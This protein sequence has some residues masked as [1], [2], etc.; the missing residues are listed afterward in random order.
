MLKAKRLPESSPT[1]GALVEPGKE[2][3]P[4][5]VSGQ[6]VC[7][8]PEVSSE[9]GRPL[10]TYSRRVQDA[11]SNDGLK[12][13]MDLVQLIVRRDVFIRKKGVIGEVEQPKSSEPD[14]P[15]Q[16]QAGTS[17]GSSEADKTPLK[18][19]K[20]LG[21]GMLPIWLKSE[22]TLDQV[23]AEEH[24]PVEAARRLVGHASYDKTRRTYAE[25]MHGL[26]E[27]PHSAHDCIFETPH[28]QRVVCDFL[29]RSRTPAGCRSVLDKGPEKDSA[30]RTSRKNV[31]YHRATKV[32]RDKSG[33][34]LRYLSSKEDK[35]MN[36]R[37]NPHLQ[38]STGRDVYVSEC[39]RLS[40]LPQFGVEQ[41]LSTNK[42]MGAYKLGPYG[43]LALARALAHNTFIIIVNL[44]DCALGD[45]AAVELCRGLANNPLV[46]ELNLANNGLTVRAGEAL[47]VLLGLGCK[48]KKEH[49]PPIQ[50]LTLDQNKHLHHG[51]KPVLEAVVHNRNLKTLSLNETGM[52]DPVGC[53]LMEVLTEM[54]GRR[55]LTKLTLAWNEMTVAWRGVMLGLAN[56]HT[57]KK[58]DLSNNGLGDTYGTL[59]AQSLASNVSL[60]VLDVCGCRF[61]EATFRALAATFVE[62]NTTL[63]MVVLGV[64]DGSQL[65]K[66]MDCSGSSLRLGLRVEKSGDNAGDELWDVL[67][68]EKHYNMKHPTVMEHTP[69]F[70]EYPCID[71]VTGVSLGITT[72]KRHPYTSGW[73]PVS[74]ATPQGALEVLDPGVQ[75]CED[76]IKEL[77]EALVEEI[78]HSRQPEL[79]C[80]RKSKLE[81]QNRM[82]REALSLTPSRFQEFYDDVIKDASLTSACVSQA[83]ARAKDG[84]GHYEEAAQ[85]YHEA[86][87]IQEDPVMETGFRHALEEINVHRE[88]NT[89]FLRHQILLKIKSVRDTHTPPKPP[90]PRP[91]TP[92]PP[93]PEPAPEPKEEIELLCWEY[94]HCIHSRLQDIMDQHKDPELEKRN[95]REIIREHDTMLHDVYEHYTSQHLSAGI[96]DIPEKINQPDSTGWV[97]ST[98]TSMTTRQRLAC[99]RDQ[100][101]SSHKTILAAEMDRLAILCLWDEREVEEY[102]HSPHINL[103]GLNFYEWVEYICRCSWDMYHKMKHLC[104]RVGFMLKT[105]MVALKDTAMWLKDQ[106]DSFGKKL[107]AKPDGYILL[108]SH[109]SKLL[110]IYKYFNTR[111]KEKDKIAAEEERKAADPFTAPEVKSK[112]HLHRTPK[113]SRGTP[114]TAGLPRTPENQFLAITP[115]TPASTGGDMC[116]S[117]SILTGI[118]KPHRYLEEHDYTMNFND[119]IRMFER[120]ELYDPNLNMKRVQVACD[121]VLMHGELLAQEHPQNVTIEF[122]F[123]QFWEALA[124]CLVATVEK[125][126]VKE[127]GLLVVI[128]DLLI[129]LF[130]PRVARV[131]P[132]R[133]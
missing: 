57:L 133:L 107:W 113:T 127:Q 114:N 1:M 118:G 38:G 115:L 17:K 106:Q 71:A 74:R 59:L 93:M 24:R 116:I 31:L 5:R 105:H 48:D 102:S 62:H 58:L 97:N 123:E 120:L 70:G 78:G 43:G 2:S 90:T 110:R 9:D 14:T 30:E 73:R 64:N 37:A 124:R 54:K 99:N 79:A 7:I 40:I 29:V 103:I 89:P 130:Y 8:K 18:L 129:N 111:E 11:R 60:E 12:S 83:C 63:Q 94:E 69:R 44:R 80:S 61:G 96:D 23:D 56:N 39:A 121:W 65:L 55:Y 49:L 75:I 126:R 10:R 109:R 92:K 6:R 68:D 15:S 53:G 47:G 26:P 77:G 36:P 4:T 50:S 25:D 42:L 108:E 104:D 98:G 21:P 117:P 67:L 34:R 32:E 20:T 28:A 66:A 119:F 128:E 13:P 81:W 41:C 16:V 19:T 52:R 88:R 84:M 91:P 122:T 46:T 86:L 51:L 100:Q 76:D 95:L 3:Q 112:L 72:P 131:L 101:W 22:D 132:G 125:S 82:Y 87:R 85:A 35:E 33:A 45:T 27:R